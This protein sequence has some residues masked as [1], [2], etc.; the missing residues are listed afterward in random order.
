MN[1]FFLVVKIILSFLYIVKRYVYNIYYVYLI[2]YVIF[3]LIIIHNIIKTLKKSILTK[4]LFF[5]R[6][7]E[8]DDGA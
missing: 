8:L 2:D 1:G 4:K 7:N 6:F 3:L 5:S